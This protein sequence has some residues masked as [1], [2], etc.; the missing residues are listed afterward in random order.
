MT[1]IAESSPGVT[2]RLAG[3]FYLLTFVAGVLSLQLRGS[4]GFAALLVS[5]LS[6]LPV[7]ILFYILFKPVSTSLSLVAAV[8]SLAGCAISVLSQFHL[9][10]TSI[11][12]LAFFGVYCLLIGYLILKSTFLPRFLGVLMGIGGLGWLT[13]ASPLANHLIPYNMAPGILAELSL[14]VWLLVKGVD[15]QRWKD[16]ATAAATG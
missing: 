9:I 6:Y 12:P 15:I 4:L 7:T 2:A 13:F 3:V 1:T 10:A 11:N 16:Q 5:T 8:F 14:T